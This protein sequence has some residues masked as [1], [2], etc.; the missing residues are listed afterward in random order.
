M[1]KYFSKVNVLY[2]ENLVNLHDKEAY[3]IH[4][5]NLKQELNHGLLFK[6]LHRVIKFNQNAWKKSYINVN[7]ELTK[8]QKMESMRKNI[9]ISFLPKQ[10]EIG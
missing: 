3:T 7:T 9:E 6:K 10:E 2:V 5:R 4:I 8:K 1:E